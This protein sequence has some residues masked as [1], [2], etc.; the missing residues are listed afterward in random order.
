MSTK[1]N[2]ND[3]PLLSLHDGEADDETMADVAALLAFDAD[4][5]PPPAGLKRRVMEAAVRDREPAF[6]FVRKEEGTWNRTPFP[7]VSSKH[8]YTDANTK[9]TTW[10]VKLEPGGKYPAHSHAEPEQCLVVEGD[11]RFGEDRFSAGDYMCSLRGSEH[12]VSTSER[13]CVLLIINSP[14]DKLHI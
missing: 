7:G 14:H 4:A 5:V 10:L 6:L 9:M 12:E 8:L 1:H 3:D 2:P 13:G 11:V